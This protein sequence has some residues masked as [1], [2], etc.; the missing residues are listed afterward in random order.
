MKR[1]RRIA[2]LIALLAT[3]L[4]AV[5]AYN[6]VRF[7][8]DASSA[9]LV[10]SATP[11]ALDKQAVADR[12]SSAIVKR[13]VSYEN[14]GEVEPAEFTA[15]HALLLQN[16]PK[17]HDT[18]TRETVDT[19]SLLYTWNGSD[20]SLAPIVLMNHIDVVPIAPGTE[21][22]WV[23]PPFSG[24]IADG[25]VWGRGTLDDKGGVVALME[26]VET[27]IT[28]GF[29]PKRT[30]LLAF[31]HDEEIGGAQGA[32]KIVELLQSRNV[33][34]ALVLDEGGSITQGILPGVQ[35]PVALVGIAEKGYLTLELTV[36][37]VGGHSSQPPAHTAIGILSA[38]IT[39][40][41]N[42]P[43]PARIDGPTLALFENTGPHMG[44]AERVVFSNL[45]LFR[46]V[47]LK[48]LA[49]MPS[50]NATIRT[51]TAVTIFNSGNKENV[52][53]ATA[54]AVV[55]FRVLPGDSLD[56]VESHVRRVLADDRITIARMPHA[57]EASSTSDPQSAEY[58]LLASTIQQVCGREVIV[59]PYL[60]LGA[61]DSRHYQPICKNIF[62]FSP[63]RLTADDLKRIHGTNERIAIDNYIE[64]VN[65]YAQ[66]I[67]NVDT[68]P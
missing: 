64:I 16:F 9:P 5:V 67:R 44:L 56:M 6:T 41:E 63:A 43:M 4:V 14:P 42:N 58:A 45:W 30:V 68:M 33:K 60:V 8:R 19:H 7:S 39:R 26:A 57:Q 52:L 11:L 31:G 21:G 22:E 40:L 25:F 20:P 49:G 66:L 36:S 28:A 23:H 34:P 47:V 24:A 2:L 61:T 18:I 53:P 15:L 62:R 54:R 65:F 37:D 27:L 51:S 38:G 32:V 50:T 17:A 46:G 10:P 3:A 59:S 29:T 48:Q 13:T 12:L 1:F 35:S 55:N